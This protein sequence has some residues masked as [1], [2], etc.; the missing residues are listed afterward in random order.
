[1]KKKKT[2]DKKTDKKGSAK[3][4]TKRKITNRPKTDALSLV[5]ADGKAPLKKRK[6]EA[7]AAE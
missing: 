4:P 1:V 3:A 7:P 2:G 6:P 5:S